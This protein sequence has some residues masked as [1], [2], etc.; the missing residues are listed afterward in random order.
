MPAVKQIS[1]IP[2]SLGP[3][4]R[5]TEEKSVQEG[6]QR[7]WTDVDQVV[8]VSTHQTI[9]L[10]A[11]V[12]PPSGALKQLHDIAAGRRHP[13]RSVGRD[14]PGRSQEKERRDNTLAVFVP[15]PIIRRTTGITKRQ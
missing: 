6:G 14:C 10:Q 8:D 7:G 4:P 5:V 3:V 12:T 11:T 1:H 2:V 13:T 15:W 9:G